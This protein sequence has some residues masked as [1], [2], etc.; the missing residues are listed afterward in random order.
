MC[1]MIYFVFILLKI[2][3]LFSFTNLRNNKTNIFLELKE[4]EK[5]DD[6]IILHTND[7][8]CGI[9]DNIGYDGLMLYKKELQKKYKNV[10]IVDAGDHIQGDII[11]LI[12]K[13]L[14][15]IEIMNKIGYNVSTI[16]NHEFDYNLGGLYNCSKKLKCGYISANFVYRN[17]KTQIFEKYK[18]LEVGN[19]KIAFLGVTT[20]Q[21][22]TKTNLYREKNKDG[23]TKYYFLTDNNG[24][25][26]Y[27]TIQIYINELKEKY[28]VDHIIIL[29][30]LG[31]ESPIPTIYNSSYFISQI[32]GI[33]AMIDGHTHQKYNKTC[34]DKN[35]NNVLLSQTGTKLNNIGVIKINSNGEFTS[36]MISEVP[37]PIEEE[38]AK[39]V[40]R[41][42]KDRWID[43]EM[44]DFL[45]NIKNSHSKELNISYGYSD[46]DFII[47]TDEIKDQHKFT[48][49]SEECTLGNLIT[50]SMRNS[51]NSDIAFKSAGSI[52]SDLLKGD[53]TVEK[54]L[55]VIPYSSSIIIKEVSGQDILDCLEHS[56]KYSPDKHSKF[57]QVSGISF[58]INTSIEST[59]ITDENEMFVK[60]DGKRRVY[61]VKVG[62][63]ILDKNK[64]YKVSIDNY[65]SEGGDGYSMFTKYDIIEITPKFDNEILGDYIQDDLNGIIPDRYKKT[66]NRIII[67][68]KEEKDNEEE[69]EEKRRIEDNDDDDI[70]ILL[71]TIIS[72]SI[73]AFIIILF[74]IYLVKKRNELLAKIKLN[75]IDSKLIA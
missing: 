48:C 66:E 32:Y 63:E 7:V 2:L 31:D 21:T 52:R 64:K 45:I 51:R 60:V 44:N 3:K 75:D 33:D 23:K 55:N 13:G 46:F 58:K 72:L 53:I 67:T 22:L 29:S 69:N 28:K 61:D 74:I 30:H 15:I 41:N 5:S 40:S 4:E 19:K 12:S 25:E 56:V 70:N 36:E 73:A 1:K 20:P 17:N 10:L 16:G 27:D 62:D 68:K 57:L 24:Q 39:K 35:G 14:D 54:I 38:G 59:V 34:K 26:L 8:H 71:I 49:R 37:K 6:I 18:I 43:K 50:D 47:S 9:M 65:L 42:S 11:G